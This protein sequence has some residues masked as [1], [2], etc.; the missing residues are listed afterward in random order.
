M[1]GLSKITDKIIAEANAEVSQKLAETDAEC[2]KIIDNYKS[3]ALAIKNELD[4]AAQKEAA[5]ILAR[6]KSGA[7]TVHRNVLLDAKGRLVD[8]AFEEAE[9]ELHSLP[10]DKYLEL[11]VSMLLCVLTQQT[12]DE[13]RSVLVYGEA[14]LSPDVKYEVMLN[15]SDRSKFGESLIA[16]VRRRMVGKEIISICE[17]VVL[18]PLAADID[19]GLIL[20]CG[21]TEINSSLS[22]IFGQIRGELEGKV[23]RILFG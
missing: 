7:E 9:R 4:A 6:T 23:S 1:T 18:S 14:S 17:R 19:G 20:K 5:A 10:D 15:A 11:L 3:R 12:E 13:K 16:G 8:K 21:D 2:K 22:T